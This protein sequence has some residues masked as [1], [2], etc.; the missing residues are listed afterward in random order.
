MVNYEYDIIELF[1]QTE[2]N[3][4]VSDQ[5]KRL[6][7]ICCLGMTQ[8]FNKLVSF[9]LLRNFVVGIRTLARTLLESNARCA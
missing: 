9:L 4:H 3:Q 7:K 5:V 2:N 6:Q 1:G 8:F